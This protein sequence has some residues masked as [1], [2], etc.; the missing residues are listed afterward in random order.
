MSKNF[1]I[2]MENRYGMGAPDHWFYLS[3]NVDVLLRNGGKIDKA[4]GC[5]V[6]YMACYPDMGR[7][8]AKA[9]ECGNL[10][11]LKAWCAARQQHLL[12]KAA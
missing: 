5:V 7:S 8:F 11:E 1:A 2:Q 10:T 6:R 3:A 9:M 4:F 12:R